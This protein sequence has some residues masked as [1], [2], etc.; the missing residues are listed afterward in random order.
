MSK[1]FLDSLQEVLKGNQHKID[2]NKNGKIDSHDFKLLRSKKPVSEDLDEPDYEGQMAKTEL[3]AICDKAN[4]LE[5]ML[6]DEDQLE[7]WV[8]SKISN[9]KMHID[10]IHDYMVYRDKPNMEAKVPNIAAGPGS[11]TVLGSKSAF[12][13]VDFFAEAKRGRPRKDGAKFASEDD[14]Q[15]ADKNIM[16]QLRKKP[17]GEHQNL[18]FNN[19]EKKKVHVIHATRALSMLQNSKPSERLDLQNSLAHSHSRFMD[20]VRT[21]KAVKDEP[22][23]KVSLA[24]RVSEEAELIDEG[25]TKLSNARLKFHATK[26]VP[27]GSYTRQEIKDEHKRRMKVDP[28]YHTAKPSL[29][30]EEVKQ[31]DEKVSVNKKEYSWGKMITV[32]HGASHTFPLHPEHQEKIAKLKDGESVS[33]TDETKSKVKAHRE[34][35]TV[36]LSHEGSSSK[37]PVAYSHFS[38]EYVEEDVAGSLHAGARGAWDSLTLGGG[39]YL[40]G[41]ADYLAKKVMGKPTDWNKEVEQEREKDTKAQTEHPTA[42]AVGEHGAT[43]ATSL[44]GAGL[45]GRI[46]AKAGIKAGAAL[47]RGIDSSKVVSALD[48]A[49]TRG[50]V[51]GAAGYGAGYYKNRAAVAQDLDKRYGVS[52]SIDE[53]VETK[54]SDRRAKKA[55]TYRDPKTGKMKVKLQSS[56]KKEIHK[57]SVVDEGKIIPKPKFKTGE[58]GFMKGGGPEQH[59]AIAESFLIE[60]SNEQIEKISLVFEKLNEKN[61]E[62]FINNASSSVEGSKAML[63]FAINIE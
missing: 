11:L 43:V 24:K 41:T 40:R 50:L 59:A 27:H 53:D 4:K 47:A 22:R 13:E 45:A 23:A 17:E 51:A 9:A 48:R 32:L 34:G 37:T 39:K 18:T 20:T 36:H 12:E 3:K 54:A 8:Q 52:E 10:A 61:Q 56:P 21:G 38:E 60:L 49:G 26:N 57:E 15:E 2:A 35:D 7:A 25:I 1:A 14:T 55:V 28:E 5:T 6:R 42:Y 63:D 31:I 62:A 33:F 29:N 46:A 19:G 30:E 58:I 44:T 16:N